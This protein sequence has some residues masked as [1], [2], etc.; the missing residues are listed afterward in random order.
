VTDLVR[1]WPHPRDV[2][3]SAA[4]MCGWPNRPACAYLHVISTGS[5]V[6]LHMGLVGCGVT[7]DGADMA[8]A[9][10]TEGEKSNGE[11]PDHIARGP[12]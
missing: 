9:A 10:D 11:F 1:P 7:G 4:S 3:S 5:T 2:L 12:A 8:R 6:G